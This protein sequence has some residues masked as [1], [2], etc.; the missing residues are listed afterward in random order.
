MLKSQTNTLNKNEPIPKTENNKK[1]AK[2]AQKSSPV[3]SMEEILEKRIINGKAE[4]LI[5]WEGYG[6]KENSW[7]PESNIYCPVMLKEFEK[8]YLAK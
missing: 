5:S 4:Y 3:F 8:K 6:P 2:K 7:E 1:F